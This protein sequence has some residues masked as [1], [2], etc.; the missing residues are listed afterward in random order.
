MLS[1]LLAALMPQ[2]P[3]T[4][5]AASSL[6][7]RFQGFDHDG[8]GQ[9]ELIA[10]RSFATRG[11]DRARPAMLALIEPRLLA[12]AK[13][14]APLTAALQRWCDDLAGEG[15]DVFAFT[16]QVT[17]AAGHQ[18]GRSLLAIRQFARTVQRELRPLSGITLIGAFPHALLVRT[19]NWWR[20][21]PI[22][23]RHGQADAATHQGCRWL[24]S[25]PEIVAHTADIV[26]A[27]LDGAW[28]R[29]YRR[30][31]TDLRWTLCIP[32]AGADTRDG[33]TF[34]LRD[35][36]SGSFVLRDFFEVDDGVVHVHTSDHGQVATPRPH[37]RDHECGPL[38]RQRANPMAVPDVP[39]ARIDARGVAFVPNPELLDADGKPRPTPLPNG[40][41]PHWWHGHWRHDLAFERQ[42]LVDFFARN[43]AYRSGERRPPQRPASLAHGLGSGFHALQPARTAWPDLDPALDVGGAPDLLAVA[44]WFAQPAELRTIR[45]HSD[46]WGSAFTACKDIAS[47]ERAAGGQPW[48][49]AV[50]GDELRPSLAAACGGGKLDFFLLRTLWQNGVTGRGASFYVHTGCEAISPPNANRLP[51]SDPGH[52]AYCGGNAVL[53][54]G[55][56]LALVG[57][58]KVFYDEPREFAATLG[59]G[60]TFGQ[61]WQRYFEVE[62]A[63]R[64]WSEIGDDIGRKRAYFWSVLGDGSLHLAA[65][66]N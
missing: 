16:M 61:A 37:R 65:G 52:G 25:Y 43:H 36:E 40:N 29:C 48:A 63:A 35:H 62:S 45:A 7:A 8:D 14:A 50:M 11:A 44:R 21:D 9:P 33:A 10:V 19:C 3:A 47:L 26:L 49:F 60:Q 57:R 2:G 12:D 1:L 34:A 32:D 42:L 53:F 38:D 20:D 54:F 59:A 56:G 39:V 31:P 22:T 46:P 58:A 66:G 24:R 30:G 27:D 13:A 4:A 55:D 15:H 51:W 23:L 41:K 64:S 18:D 5:D 28:E 6:A 17:D